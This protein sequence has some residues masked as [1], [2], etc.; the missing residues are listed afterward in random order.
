MIEDNLL[1]K[2]LIKATI[3]STIQTII[4]AIDRNGLEK[5]L[6]DL[7]GCYNKNL[8]KSNE[9]VYQALLTITKQ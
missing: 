4:E 8:D 3:C 6:E 9:E 5:T 2:L 1:S 7:R